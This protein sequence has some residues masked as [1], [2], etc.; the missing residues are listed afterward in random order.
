[1]YVERVAWQSHERLVAQKKFFG[2]RAEGRAEQGGA[3]QRKAVQGRRA[4]T[5][6]GFRA[7]GRRVGIL[8]SGGSR[9]PRP[10]RQR[11]EHEGTLQTD[12]EQRETPRKEPR[13]EGDWSARKDSER[14][15]RK[16]LDFAELL[17][18]KNVNRNLNSSGSSRKSEN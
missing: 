17:Q 16:M 5:E 9:S 14:D 13:G 11:S 8:P 4:C 6:R 2:F 18:K 12:P 1:M 7:K 10:P 3:G 15:C